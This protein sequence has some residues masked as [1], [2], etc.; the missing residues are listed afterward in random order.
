MW[1]QF[2]IELNQILFSNILFQI[3]TYS[4]LFDLLLRHNNLSQDAGDLS[5]DADDMDTV[6]ASLADPD[7]E[8]Y[9]TIY[10]YLYNI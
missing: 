2:E 1:V 6:M 10:L 8:K 7:S 4:G 5:Q 3:V 9:Y